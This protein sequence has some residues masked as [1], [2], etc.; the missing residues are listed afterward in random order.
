M[1]YSGEKVY[2]DSNYQE[3]VGDGTQVVAGG[4]VRYL[5]AQPRNRP[6][7]ALAGSKPFAADFQ[8]I[9]RSEWSARIKEMEQ[10]QSRLSDLA[11]WQPLDQNGTSYCWIFGC[12][13]AL[14]LTRAAQG[15]P[16]V[17]LSPAS[18]GCIIKD[19]RNQ[20]GWGGDG[21]EFLSQHGCCN[22]TLWPEDAINRKYATPAADADRANHKILEFWEGDENNF[23]Q[24]MTLLLLRYPCPLGLD[25]WSHLICACD[26][27]EIESGRYGVRIWNSWGNW[28][29]ANRHGMMGFSVLAENKARGDFYGVRQAT[30]A[31][32]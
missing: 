4:E 32:S 13:N 23:N 11:T 12:V 19:F 18:A 9:P 14:M 16:H 17:R 29:A 22:T 6:Y 28:G 2:D 24:L 10:R 20:G 7:G 1:M 3:L 8:V 27:V 26:P 15:L 5:A 25:W 30:A 31:T 21:I